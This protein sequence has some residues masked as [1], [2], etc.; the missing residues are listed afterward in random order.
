MAYFD[1]AIQAMRRG[2]P[3]AFFEDEFRTPLDYKTTAEILV[4]LLETDVS[5]VL[6]VAGAGRVS[7]F[8]LMRRIAVA[9][10]LDPGLVRANRQ[11]D[12]PSPEPRPGDLSL[13]TTKLA[14]LLPDF[15]RPGIEEAV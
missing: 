14:G 9:M 4:K 6:H 8:E 7:R 2:E 11:A 1:Q 15:R 12:A 13:D 3:R 10:G 5:G